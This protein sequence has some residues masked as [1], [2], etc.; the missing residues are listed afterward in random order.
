MAD[1]LSLLYSG[2]VINQNHAPESG[3]DW[4]ALSGTVYQTFHL[5]A[6]FA[7][8]GTTTPPLT[9]V[10][11][12]VGVTAVSG[13]L[14]VGL[15]HRS[16]FGSWT[17]LATGVATGAPVLDDEVWLTCMFDAVDVTGMESDDFRISLSSPVGVDRVWYTVPN[18]MADASAKAL[19]ADGTTALLDTSREYSFNFRLL[20]A[21]ADSGTDFL[22]S[23]Y[24][25][26]V[27]RKSVSATNP[28]ASNDAVW[29]SSPQPSQFAVVSQYFDVSD[30]GSAVVVDGVVMDPVTPGIYAHAYYCN[31]GAAG[32]T[33]D[34]WEERVWIPIPRSYKVLGRDTYKFPAPVQAK[35]LKLEYSHLQ[36]RG[37]PAGSFQ[38]SI[39]YKK[40]PK[41]VLDYFLLATASVTGDDQ[42]VARSVTVNYD[43]YSLAFDY[44]RDDLGTAADPPPFLTPEDRASV[45]RFVS[46]RDDKSDVVDPRTAAQINT[47]LA[48]F[49]IDPRARVTAR[50]LLGEVMVQT[51]GPSGYPVETLPANTP[52]SAAVSTLD[53]ENVVFEQSFPV[54]FFYLACRHRY[55]VVNAPLTHDRAYFA[56]MREVAFVR[57]HYHAEADLPMYVE[58]LGDYANA[59]RN[60]F[61]PLTEPSVT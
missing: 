48:P 60:D 2:I 29:L 46:S 16:F 51:P 58:T 19:A 27:V 3:S 17:P 11:I 26:A 41:W 43:A 31:D 23:Q 33:D 36:A 52:V 61:L 38:K 44:Y 1:P 56:G 53:R 7:R 10:Q 40:H 21:V 4:L 15:E 45:E 32:T 47:V 34:E 39:Q 49:L 30:S 20:G 37:Y 8:A 22:G 14:A 54:M 59:E 50:T 57:E 12:R 24:R 55:R 9:G 28:T 18:P 13:S 5:P 35:Y 42:F 6:D 25:S